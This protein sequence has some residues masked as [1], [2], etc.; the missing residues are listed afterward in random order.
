MSYNQFLGLGGFGGASSGV[1]GGGKGP[2]GDQGSFVWS[3]GNP[4]NLDQHFRLEDEELTVHKNVVPS[5][6]NI[7]DLGV[8]DIRFRTLHSD[9]VNASKVRYSNGQVE[10]SYDSDGQ[11]RIKVGDASVVFGVTTLADNPDKIDPKYVDFTGLRFIDVIGGDQDLEELLLER[12]LLQSGDYFVVNTDGAFGYERFDDIDNVASR[13][14]IIVFTLERFVK[15][16]FRI[17]NHS[18]STIHIADGAVTAPKLT[19]GCVH[20][21]HVADGSISSVKLQ[22]DIVLQNVTVNREFVSRTFCSNQEETLTDPMG[23]SHFG[24]TFANM[25]VVSVG[26]WRVSTNI[27]SLKFE[28]W[29]GVKWVNKFELR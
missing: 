23:N 5:G 15:V 26:T 9:S 20:P 7:L 2:K 18:V 3:F 6:D 27:D 14:D 28:I 19:E 11:H 1:G 29:N 13:G 21:I 8:G 10:V 4:P 25:G 24:I 22:P 12:P 17:P 16:P